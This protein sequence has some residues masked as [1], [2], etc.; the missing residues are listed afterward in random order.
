MGRW[1]EPFLIGRDNPY[2]YLFF[3]CPTCFSLLPFLSF[4]PSL[5]YLVRHFF[6]PFDPTARIG[7]IVPRYKS[8][9]VSRSSNLAVLFFVLFFFAVVQGS[10]SENDSQVS[11]PQSPLTAPLLTGVNW[12][13]YR[14][15]AHPHHQGPLT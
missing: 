8:V 5:L 14:P 1:R 10:T 15:L 13:S 2:R 4:S 12:H 6:H 3:F 9:V 11:R 7:C